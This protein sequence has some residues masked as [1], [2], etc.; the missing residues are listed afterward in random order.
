L[1]VCLPGGPGFDPEAYCAPL[2]LPGRELLI[3]A[4]RGTGASSAPATPDGFRIAGYV[5]DVES[6]RV[7]LGVEALTL[8]GH[9]HGGCVALAYA[10]RSPEHV[11]R[12]VISVAPPRMDD[13]YQA[14]VAEVRRRYA[15]TVADGAARL[16]AAEQAN[17]ALRTDIDADERRRQLQIL[18][19]RYVVR[20]GDAETAYLERLCAAPMNWAPV[21]PMYAE[22]LDGLDLLQDAAAVTA[23]TLVL[24]S[25]LDV[26]A[27]ASTMRLL[28]D[29]LPNARYHEFGDVGHFPEV[30][31]SEA[32]SSALVTFLAE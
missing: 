4:P 25:E 31:A 8:Y 10:Q 21:E 1:V 7:H 3:F 5:E 11:Q 15:E 29:A 26:V 19:A 28:A 18:M 27:P 30:E 14:A 12:L 22:M 17:A 32:F 2:V 23:P 24:A 6:L 9:S 13:G 16:A 20:Q